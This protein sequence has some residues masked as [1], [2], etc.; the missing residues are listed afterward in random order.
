MP[1]AGASGS[2][3]GWR[4]E[5]IASIAFSCLGSVSRRRRICAW[6]LTIISRLLKSCAMLPV[7]WPSA[8]IF[9]DWASCSC[10]RSSA[11]CASRRSVMSRVILAKPTSVPTSSRIASM[12][13]LAQNAALVAPH[14]PAFGSILALV[15]GDLERARRLAAL[16]L[17]LGVEA[18]EMLADDLGRRVLVD[19]LRA[20]VPVGDVA[21]R[22]EHEDRVVGDALDEQPKAPFAFHQRLLRLAAL[23]DV[24]LERGFDAL[25]LL[26]LGVQHLVGLFE[27][28]RCARRTLFSRSS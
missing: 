28:R 13:T 5:W 18:A 15:G 17:L 22:I 24:V 21:V 10:A 26:D 8:S 9:C 2:R 23:G 11:A 14:A 7:S 20:R 12:T 1:A 19:A 16:P 3:R 6:P 25:S 4:A 27:R